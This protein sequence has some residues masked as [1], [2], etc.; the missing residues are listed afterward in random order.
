MI[1]WF[2]L[3]GDLCHI[4][5]FF[6]LIY[7]MKTSKSAAGGARNTSGDEGQGQRDGQGVAWYGWVV[8][9]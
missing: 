3:L 8:G 1:T 9:S 2:Q 5:S 7:R 4:A 6:F